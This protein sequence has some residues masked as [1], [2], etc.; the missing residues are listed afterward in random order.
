LFALSAPI[1]W[2]SVAAIRRLALLEAGQVLA[3]IAVGL[4][5]A[6]ACDGSALTWSP[7]LYGTDPVTFG[8][9]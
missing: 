5:A 3:G 6:T 8:A 1:C 2:L 9:A 4:V 7:W